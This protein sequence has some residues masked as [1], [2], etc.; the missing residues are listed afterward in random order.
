MRYLF[1]VLAIG[2]AVSATVSFADG[3][4]QNEPMVVEDMCEAYENAI[5]T[6]TSGVSTGRIQTQADLDALRAAINF[7]IVTDQLFPPDRVFSPAEIQDFNRA[8][9]GSEANLTPSICSDH[10]HLDSVGIFRPSTDS[11]DKA[12]CSFGYLGQDW[13]VTAAH[14]LISEDYPNFRT[15]DEIVLS[16][17]TLIEGAKPI[18]GCTKVR[19]CVPD[20][21]AGSA[22]KPHHR[23]IG[24]IQV[25]SCGFADTYRPQA[26][27]LAAFPIETWTIGESV[28]LLGY[29]LDSGA[30]VPHG[31]KPFSPDTLIWTGLHKTSGIV[32]DGAL[33]ENPKAG[34]EGLLCHGNSTLPGTSG[35][36]LSHESGIMQKVSCVHSYPPDYSIGCGYNS[37]ACTLVTTGDVD[38]FETLKMGGTPE[39]YTCS[40]N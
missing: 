40:G 17:G 20:E 1:E 18:E 39:G 5:D 29:L 38:A 4:N 28:R 31:S 32:R 33:I 23:D 27:E 26:L 13:F 30:P 36:P 34:E 7:P 24:F 10:S 35:S 22:P 2:A 16:H 25:Q 15:I 37:N 8:L 9:L 19:T 12:R 6:F 14:C 11:D 3:H 21:W